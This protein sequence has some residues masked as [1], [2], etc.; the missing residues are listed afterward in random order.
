[1]IALPHIIQEHNLDV[2]E[3]DLKRRMGDVCTKGRKESKIPMPTQSV[4]ACDWGEM[5]GRFGCCE[6]MNSC[7]G[8]CKISFSA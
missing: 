3:S 5:V 7:G 2:E 8:V 4:C 6:R 1:M